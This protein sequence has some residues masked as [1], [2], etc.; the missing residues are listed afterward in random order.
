VCLI[1]P[2]VSL[3]LMLSIHDQYSILKEQE[4]Q[5]AKSAL[6]AEFDAKDELNAKATEQ[7][8]EKL[9]EKWKS[10]SQATGAKI[11]AIS[12]QQAFSE[13]PVTKA[14]DALEEAEYALHQYQAGYPSDKNTGR[15]P[16]RLR[17]QSGATFEN[18]QGLDHNK[19]GRNRDWIDGN[20]D[21]DANPGAAW[22][23]GRQKSSQYKDDESQPSI[24]HTE[25]ADHTRYLSQYSILAARKTGDTQ[26]VNPSW[27]F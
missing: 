19:K 14:I 1:G 4:R 17:S 13:N 10:R 24:S 5:Q 20:Q 16:L 21:R 18:G 9:R 8:L 11:T 27:R 6:W 22:V 23:G 3:G 25:R 15:T 12:S 7:E 26:A 2:R